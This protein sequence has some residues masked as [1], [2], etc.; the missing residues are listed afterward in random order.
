MN[1][2]NGTIT[3]SGALTRAR[4][5]SPCVA[6]RTTSASAGIVFTGVCSTVTA[7]P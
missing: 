5:A 2:W 6:R 7:C 1:T 3:L 4:A